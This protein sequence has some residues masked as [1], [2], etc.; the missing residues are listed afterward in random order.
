MVVGRELRRLHVKRTLCTYEDTTHRSRKIVEREVNRPHG[1][2]VA[3]RAG[4]RSHD[5]HRSK[6]KLFVREERKTHL[7]RKRVNVHQHNTHPE[8]GDSLE[9]SRHEVDL[10]DT[11][12]TGSH[13][14]SENHVGELLSHQVATVHERGDQREDRSADVQSVVLPVLHIHV[15]QETVDVGGRRRHH[16]SQEQE[17]EEREQR[18]VLGKSA[19]GTLTAEDQSHTLH[20]GILE[21][22]Q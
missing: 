12:H 6:G 11:R 4:T 5:Q 20:E 18:S 19:V 10:E 1:R 13:R 8:E 17:E 7:T 2:L 9:Q 15:R 21:G 16:A 3:D 14:G 22:L